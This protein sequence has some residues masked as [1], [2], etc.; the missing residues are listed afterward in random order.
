MKVYSATV[1]IVLLFI[2][3][4]SAAQPD[5]PWV[6]TKN[7]PEKTFAEY[8]NEF[9]E[10]WEGKTPEKGQGFK[11]FK[12]WEYFWGTRVLKDG[13]LPSS[14]FI[15]NEINKAKS[16]QSNLEKVPSQWQA[17][18]PFDYEL[19]GSWSAGHGRV[20]AVTV[21]PN[22]SNTIFIGAPAGGIWKSADNGQTWEVL[23]DDL[24]VIGVSA[25]AI[26]PD[27]SDIIYIGTGD[28]DAGDTFSIGL[29]KSIDGGNT[30][31]T[32]GLTLSGNSRL[33][34]VL[35]D[36]VNSE[37]IYVATNQGVYKST[38][39]GSSFSVILSENVRDLAF[40]PGNSQTIY[41]V[42][43]QSFYRSVNGGISFFPISSGLPTSDV[44]RIV[45]GVSP[46]QPGFVYLLIANNS[47]GYKGLYL[48]E[49][50][51]VSFS[52][53]DN[54]YDIFESNQ[55]WYDLAIAVDPLNADI[56]YTGVLNLWK[57]TDKGGPNA[58]G[59]ARFAF[60][61]S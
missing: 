1:L 26:D 31:N 8:Q 14:A 13:R 25:I 24:G 61:W 16:K 50:S 53:K 51:G 30:W 57:S 35:I 56:I 58:G 4:S 40:K 45:I 7:T 55:A 5:G 48:S 11:Q 43:P 59:K 52:L 46:A 42:S 19:T 38:N 49:N 9:N 36:P 22:D 21:D 28:D 39:G 3:L 23:N 33:S 6:K 18:G 27:N 15:F 34:N 2:S 20:N 54:F 37:T 47:S 12:R 32:T 41:A 29:M 10:Y 17:I 44:S 60:P